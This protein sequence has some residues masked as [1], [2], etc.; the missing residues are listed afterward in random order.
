[1]QRVDSIC[2]EIGYTKTKKIECFQQEKSQCF[3]E[4]FVVKTGIPKILYKRIYLNWMWCLNTSVGSV[5]KR[6]PIEMTFPSSNSFSAGEA[7]C[8]EPRDWNRKYYHTRFY[9]LTTQIL[10]FPYLRKNVFISNSNTLSIQK[11]FFPFV[12]FY[13]PSKFFH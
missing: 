3:L 13:S 6:I 1:M 5:H 2:N 8:W 10:V 4:F 11:Q 12:Q 7:P 9:N